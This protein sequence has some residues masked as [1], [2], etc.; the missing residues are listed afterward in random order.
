LAKGC[1]ILQ[2]AVHLKS[3]LCLFN[4]HRFDEQTVLITTTSIMSPSL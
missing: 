2:S 3:K 1:K 4:V